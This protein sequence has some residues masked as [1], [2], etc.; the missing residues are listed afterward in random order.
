MAIVN[1]DIRGTEIISTEVLIYSD[2]NVSKTQRL[3]AKLK[4]TFDI[5]KYPF[6]DQILKVIIASTK[7][8]AHDLRL[9]PLACNVNSEAFAHSGF[10]LKSTN[11]TV[12]EESVAG[13]EKKSRGTL[14]LTMHHSTTSAWRLEEAVLVLVACG[15]LVFWMPIVPH[16]TMPR[17]AMS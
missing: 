2:G 1:R 13:D 6:D 11:V 3:L 14:T 17:L 9:E 4:N 16:F 7:Y 15:Y 8:F 12:A 10:S 5:E